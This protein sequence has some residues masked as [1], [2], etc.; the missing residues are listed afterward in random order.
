M[1][2]T[3]RFSLEEDE[4][5]YALRKAKKTVKQVAVILRRSEHSVEAR[6]RWL[7]VT[8]E[9]RERRRQIE[10]SRRRTLGMRVRG[11][12]NWSRGHIKLAPRTYPAEV[13]IDRAERERAQRSL[14][15]VI[16]GDPPPGWSALDRK[17]QEVR[18]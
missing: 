2:I 7:H 18:A 10:Y 1:K 17:Q 8:E 6:W 11:K 3:G 13:F 9:E 4:Q 14:T 15:G 12:K 16:C 5:L